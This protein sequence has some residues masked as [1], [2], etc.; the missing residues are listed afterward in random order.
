MFEAVL[1]NGA[2]FKKLIEA[3]K[4]LV[5]DVNFDCGDEG[6]TV[7]AMDGSNVA[8]VSLRMKAGNNEEGAFES[9]RC[10][11]QFSM[12]IQMESLAKIFK[13][14]ENDAKVHIK[15][16]DD[17]DTALFTFENESKDVTT[18]FEMKLI[19]IEAE[20]LGI[21]DQT[22]NCEIKMPS[23][24]YATM[25][26]HL[27]VFGDTVNVNVDKDSAKFGVN[28]DIG[29]GNVVLKPRTSTK[30]AECVTMTVEDPVNL[31]F[32]LRYL[33]SFG[34]AATLSDTVTLSL[35]ADVPLVVSFDLEDERKGNVS[36]F[37][38]PKIDE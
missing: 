8:L 27:A 14:C 25:I 29:K 36:F 13:L 35:S 28:G 9:Y 21:P 17:A 37:L 1:A 11:R 2:L 19:D 31:S 23:K 38:A 7:Q 12:G 16:E 4:D 26:G 18:D 20:Q 22:Y 3:I 6:I 10:D 15:V 32:A 30:D 34:K 33:T 24:E 5:K